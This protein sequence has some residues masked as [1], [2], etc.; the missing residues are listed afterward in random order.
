MH[1]GMVTPNAVSLEYKEGNAASSEIYGI[2]FPPPH[3]CRIQYSPRP[4]KKRAAPK[5]AA[6]LRQFNRL[7]LEAH[8][9]FHAKD[10]RRVVIA[11]FTNTGFLG[12]VLVFQADVA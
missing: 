3:E 1:S 6:R 9:G 4:P 12:A 2:L 11:A 10:G 7:G 8:H 5:E